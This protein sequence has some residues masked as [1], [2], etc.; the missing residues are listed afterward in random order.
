M[1][2][3]DKI[4]EIQPIFNEVLHYADCITTP[5]KDMKTEHLFH[6]WAVNKQKFFTAFGDSLIKEFPEQAFPLSK[7]AKESLIDKLEAKLETMY[8]DNELNRYEFEN[9]IK[10]INA[11][12]STFFNNITT[13]DFTLI[14]GVTIIPKNTKLVK[15]FKYIIKNKDDSL[16]KVQ[17]IVSKYIQED[18]IKGTLCF[19]IHPLDYISISENDHGWRSCHALDGEYCSGN[20]EY[21]S[22]PS[23]IICYLKTSDE[24]RK[25]PNFPSI[26]KWNSKAWRV[27]LFIDDKMEN[28]WMNKPYPYQ[29]N[30]L[31][32]IVLKHSAQLFGK[33]KSHYHNWNNS[34]K[35]VCDYSYIANPSDNRSRLKELGTP[36]LIREY[37]AF[38]VKQFFQV[39]KKKHFYFDILQS[40]DYKFTPKHACLKDIT[41]SQFKK[42]K[43][44]VGSQVLCVNC[45]LNEVYCSSAHLCEKCLVKHS[46]KLSSDIIY[47]EDCGTRMTDSYC[48]WD[49]RRDVQ[50]CQ[51]C[52]EKLYEECPHCGEW[53]AKGSV[54]DG[55]CYL[56]RKE[57]VKYTLN[58]LSDIKIDQIAKVDW[59]INDLAN[60]A[61]EAE[62]TLD[63]LR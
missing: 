13:A 19:S 1:N 55:H 16:K 62:P 63:D 12:R 40:S 52:Y 48:R 53:V 35:F 21:M 60:A 20:I 23:T 39:L 59:S 10:F 33:N 5:L 11:N 38:S 18:C 51:E 29:N 14:D 54:E 24:M 36:V 26:I 34:Y 43:I 42:H 27:L 30:I 31:E 25:L 32:D 37:E 44:T 47:C 2:L 49:E 15:D 45:G 46:K 56:C 6:N 4:S 57:T 41:L 50:I 17:Q 22:D 61:M 28:I 9:L 8:L 58:N 7:E 3:T